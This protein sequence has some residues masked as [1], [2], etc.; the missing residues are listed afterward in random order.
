MWHTL[1]DF[2]V[3]RMVDC[4][5]L[6]L[7]Y[8]LQEDDKL[9]LAGKDHPALEEVLLQHKGVFDNPP[10]GLPPDCS[11]KLCLKTGNRQMQPHT[12][13]SGCRWGS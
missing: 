5:K 10:S 7:L 3:A 13:S 8:M 1:L 4:T 9:T 12:Q 6:H 11:I 2:G